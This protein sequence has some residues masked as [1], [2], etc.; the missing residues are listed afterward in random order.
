MAAV[1]LICPD[2][3][4]SS[5]P[6][7]RRIVVFP[8]PDGPTSATNEPRSKAIDT[9][10]TAT[11]DPNDLDA[12]WSA[13]DVAVRD[14]EFMRPKFL[15]PEWMPRQLACIGSATHITLQ[16]MSLHRLTILRAISLSACVVTLGCDGT[17]PTTEQS[18]SNMAPA[19][20]VAVK[21]QLN[22]VAE[23]EF[24]GFYEAARAG[25]VA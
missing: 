1:P 25:Y 4:S 2:D 22:W 9:R 7:M 3:A 14:P 10:S 6:S 11:T 13:S 8:Q 17:A 23:P 15:C 18:T 5:P 21:L 16:T 19:A 20:A 24:G 12:S